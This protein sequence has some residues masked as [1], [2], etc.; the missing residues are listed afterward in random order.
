MR[1]RF[2]PT[3]CL[4]VAGVLTILYALGHAS[5]YPWTPGESE[6]ARAIASQMHGERF[7]VEGV[8]R[9]YGDFY[10][11]F[12]IIITGLMIP[13]GVVLVQLG[14]L[15]R[16]SPRSV[17][18]I[19]AVIGLAFAVNALLSHT[20]FFAIPTVFAVAIVISTFAAVA[21]AGRARA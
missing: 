4:R 11:G 19:A 2:T 14:G 21:L 20:F 7:S 17:R 16:E 9:S 12:G 10:V 1:E 5:G 15:A 13:L 6:A 8:L 3:S 18:P